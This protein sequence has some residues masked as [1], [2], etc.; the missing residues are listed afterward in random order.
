MAEVLRF[1]EA[2]GGTSLALAEVAL[3]VAG[4]QHAPVLQ[5]DADA[6]GEA[7]RQQ[8]PFHGCGEYLGSAHLAAKLDKVLFFVAAIT[9]TH[10]HQSLGEG[11][12]LVIR[13]GDR[14]AVNFLSQGCNTK[15]AV[16]IFWS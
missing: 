13:C 4:L 14:I 5:H 15:E 9:S 12:I 1:A 10:G 6:A 16:E 8:K 7:Q 11:R 3:F 2:G